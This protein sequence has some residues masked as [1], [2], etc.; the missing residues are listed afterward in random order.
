MVAAGGAAKPG[1]EPL[2]DV[3][4][5]QYAAV[6]AAAAEEFSLDDILLIEEIQP[7][8]W[9]LAD[10]AWTELVA[11]DPEV[12]ASFTKELADAEDWLSRKVTPLEADLDAWVG[13]LITFEAAPEATLE[14]T[15][16][17]I[18]DVSRLVRRWDQRKQ[19][20][21]EI[22]K[23]LDAARAKIQK[24]GRVDLPPVQVEL[25]ALKRSR[26][27]KPKRPDE[28]APAAPARSAQREAS[29]HVT[30]DR[31]AALVAELTAKGAQP[32]KV[33]A[34]RGLSEADFD[35]I[36]RVWTRRI[37]EDR[38]TRLDFGRLLAHQ[39]SRIVSAGKAAAEAAQEDREPE[40]AASSPDHTLDPDARAVAKPSLP[41]GPV[42]WPGWDLT[43]RSAPV[44]E[45]EPAPDAG[46]TL[47]LDVAPATRPPSLPFAREPRALPSPAA[48]APP[49]PP[50]KP[51]TPTLS[52]ERYASLCVELGLW[53][54]R[55]AAIL[56]QYGL[57]E[58]DKSAIDARFKA[59]FAADASAHRRWFEA[60]E[61]YLAWLVS[62]GRLTS[63]P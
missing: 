41:F 60:S 31:Y 42:G 36:E 33:L 22:G 35:A 7:E 49:P 61:T 28:P 51:N 52:T 24:Q 23:K 37:E 6:K 19:K 4:L 21:P 53:P 13:F 1:S 3:T 20:E 48:S 57:S 8:P 54:D 16:L 59:S 15:K 14:K 55:A 32:D 39:R 12:F 10:E 29:A 34:S 50:S 43:S 62:G 47:P 45:L 5:Q 25:L 17:R 40:P 30:L 44:R 38:E 46:S 18:S 63:P 56:E 9:S 11:S 58:A 27:A 26:A 2:H